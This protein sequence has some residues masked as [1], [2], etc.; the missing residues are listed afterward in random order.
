[1]ARVTIEEAKLLA[2]QWKTQNEEHER[3]PSAAYFSDVSAHDLIGMWHTG[4]NLDGKKLTKR[5]FGCLV[6][7]WAEVFG[8]VP[9]KRRRTTASDPAHELLPTSHR[10]ALDEKSTLKGE[11]TSQRFDAADLSVL[12]PN[13]SAIEL[14]EYIGKPEGCRFVATEIVVGI[15]APALFQTDRLAMRG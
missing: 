8:D 7:R 9:A 4:K 10:R 15:V 6:E 14:A 11:R 2:E 3:E 12:E 1:M 13:S 5:E